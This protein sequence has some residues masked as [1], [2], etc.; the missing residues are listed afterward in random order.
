MYDITIDKPESLTVKEFI[1]VL[2][3]FDQDA[4]IITDVGFLKG[5]ESELSQVTLK[6]KA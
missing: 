3:A 5:I 4:Q 2:K 1:K 6:V